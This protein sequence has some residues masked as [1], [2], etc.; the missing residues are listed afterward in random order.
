MTRNLVF[1]TGGS[2]GIGLALAETVPF[3]SVHIYDISRR[4]SDDFDHVAADLANPESWDVLGE[5][6]V[7]ELEGFGGER[8][9]LMHCAGTLDPIGFAGEVKAEAYKRNVLLN[10]AAPQVLGDAFLD[11]A[12]RTRA[13]C[14]LVML[15]SG[16]ARTVYEGWSSYGAGKAAVDQWVRAAGAE[17]VRRGNHCRV[18]SVAPGIVATAMQTEIRKTSAD[19][20]PEVAKFRDLYEQDQLRDPW[21]V[22]REIWALLERDLPNGAVIDLREQGT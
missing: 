9:V 3:D 22:A 16:A 11:A 17:Q 19:R 10:S 7:R 18:L 5:F 13:R 2:S 20:F 21:K 4:G 12:R 1:I 14:H 6:F 15:T 8:A